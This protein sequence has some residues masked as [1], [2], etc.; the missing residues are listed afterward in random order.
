M[1]ERYSLVQKLNFGFKNELYS[2]YLGNQKVFIKKY[3]IREGRERED[4][5]KVETELKCYQ[6][7]TSLALPKIV[8]AQP[9]EHCLV[10]EWLDFRPFP[11][12][13][14]ALATAVGLWQ[15][16][17]AEITPTF[18]PQID[19]TYYEQNLFRRA[20]EL[21][22]LGI[23]TQPEAV[24]ERIRQHEPELR[25]G[26][27]DFSHGDLYPGNLKLH[28]GQPMLF[29]YEHAHA[30]CRFYDVACLKVHFFGT[31]EDKFLETL[32]ADFSPSDQALYQAMQL[33]R[34][35]DILYA[36]KNHHEMVGFGRAQQIVASLR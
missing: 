23:L 18:V 30:D 13:A 21:G 25:E 19:W 6:N 15:T 17:L 5:L 4:R 1:F 26:F 16:K 14:T 12:D 11:D 27:S 28:H 22:Q 20:R 33:R 3:V 35:I 29:D 7:I 8:E 9:E 34:S 32:T 31:A 24:I 2:G 10:L 36:F